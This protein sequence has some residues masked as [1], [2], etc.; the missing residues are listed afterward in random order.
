[1]AAEPAGSVAAGAAGEQAA[2]AMLK[3][4]KRLN[5]TDILRIFFLLLTNF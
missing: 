2:K 1:V 4:T 3:T 5:K